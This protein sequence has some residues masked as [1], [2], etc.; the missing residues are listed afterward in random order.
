MERL[1]KISVGAKRYSTHW[2]GKTTSWGKLKSALS[3]VKRTEENMAAYDRLPREEKLAIKDVGGFVGGTLE[4]ENRKKS[5]VTGRT[6]FTLDVDFGSEDIWDLFNLFIGCSAVLYS[7]HS[8]RKNG[9]RHFRIVGP[10]TRPVSPIEHEA[11]SRKLAETIGIEYFDDST[12]E[13]SRLMYWPSVSSDQEYVYETC[14]GPELDPDKVLGLYGPADEWADPE[15]WPRSSRVAEARKIS[16]DKQGD[17][18]QKPGIIGQFNR[19]YTIPTAISRFLPDVYTPT[20]KDDRYTYA[21]GTSAAGLVLYDGDTFAFSNHATD[22]ISG[23]LVNA[24]DLVRIHKFGELD[25]TLRKEREVTDLPSFKAMAELALNDAGVKQTI[26]RE[27]QDDLARDFAGLLPEGTDLSAPPARYDELDELLSPDGNK[28]SATADTSWQERL[29]MDRSGNVEGTAKNVYVIMKLDRRLAKAFAYNEFAGKIEVVRPL[30]W[31]ARAFSTVWRDEDSSCLRNYLNFYYGMTV[32]KIADDVMQ[33]V[34][35]ENKFH[36]VKDYLGSCSWDGTPRIDTLFI[37]YL[38]A[39]DTPYVREVSR[40][41]LLAAV[42]RIYQPGV[43]FD[44]MPILYGR[45][46]IGKSTL[47]QR[48]AG[49][50]YSENLKDVESKDAL[51]CMEGRWILEMG[52]LRAK[53]RADEEAMKAFLSRQIDIYRPAFGR[54]VKEIPRQCVFI[55]TTNDDEFIQDAEGDRRFWPITCTGGHIDEVFALDRGTV[56]QIWGEAV[57]MYQRHESLC[58]SSGSAKAV[59]AE[60]SKFLSDAETGAMILDYLAQPVP[61]NWNSM[62]IREKELYIPGTGVNEYQREYTCV[63]EIVAEMF[64]GDFIKYRLRVKRALRSTGEWGATGKNF[65][66]GPGIGSQKAYKRVKTCDF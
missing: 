19:T 20:D 33:E 32:T 43:K 25:L 18:L 54:Y 11:I 9:P 44:E 42:S 1:L 45:A 58:L 21:A 38:G 40:K 29:T 13:P 66:F 17:P 61:E 63:A 22:P 27:K 2:A 39:E 14:D 23:L 35:L 62:T 59:E 26:V 8:D 56:N 46:G 49:E 5:A 57:R 15:N 47:I 7:T 28:P 65:R 50:W 3:K 4:G 48:L 6:L 41:T 31:R 53:R 64:R 52:E 60:R 37:D 34:A 51:Q 24:F 12:Y 36:P 55:G 30:P 16:K 10:Y